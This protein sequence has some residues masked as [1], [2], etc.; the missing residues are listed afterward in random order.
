MEFHPT[1]IDEIE[2]YE[3]LNES[4]FSTIHSGKNL[5][6]GERVAVKIIYKNK[7]KN[8]DIL[9]IIKSESTILKMVSHEN[10]IRLHF[11]YETE[12]E[13]YIITDEYSNGDLYKYFNYDRF[14]PKRAFHIFFQMCKAVRYLHSLGIVH[15]DIK[16]ENILVGEDKFV[17]CDFGFST[18]RRN[19]RLLTE[20]PGTLF[21]AAPEIIDGEPY[22]GFPADIWSLGV[23][24][25]LLIEG[26]FPFT[27]NKEKIR[28]L[29]NE[30][31]IFDY[32]RGDVKD[33]ITQMLEVNENKRI[34]IKGVL[35]HHW[36]REMYR[37]YSIDPKETIYTIQ[38]Y[39]GRGSPNYLTNPSLERG[40]SALGGGFMGFFS[41]IFN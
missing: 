6:T 20:F 38:K 7:I 19:K 17:L 29:V 4:S 9:S 22:R 34:T 36:M 26:D 39:G 14:T 21:Y 15:R 18:I 28:R 11:S 31:L 3:L 1:L 23:L 32:A 35:N 5:K 13:I 2:I 30:P 8:N 37:I 25:Y 41:T 10:I 27:G 12:G 16:L 40:L 24:L 33:L